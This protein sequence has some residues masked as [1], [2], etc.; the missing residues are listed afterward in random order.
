MDAEKRQD[1]SILVKPFAIHILSSLFVNQAN[2]RPNNVGFCKD[3][4][5]ASCYHYC[6]G[7]HRRGANRDKALIHLRSAVEIDNNDPTPHYKMYTLYRKL[8]RSQE[9]QKELEVF[10]KLKAQEDSK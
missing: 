7:D 5:L 10:K 4:A 1:Y 6:D 3:H 9:A 2:W 8:D